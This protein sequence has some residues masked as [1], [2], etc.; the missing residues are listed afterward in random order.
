MAVQ[1]KPISPQDLLSKIIR[2]ILRGFDQHFGI[3]H[4]PDAE[5]V[6]VTICGQET[7]FQ[8]TRQVLSDGSP[9]PATGRWQFEKGG[10]VR[11]V[12]TH[13]ASKNFAK[14]CVEARGVRWDEAAVWAALENDDYLACAFARLLMWTDPYAVPTEEQA[15]WTMYAD[16]LWRPGKPHPAAWPSNWSIGTEV[17]ESP[18][19]PPGPVS[20]P[21]ADQRAVLVQGLTEIGEAVLRLRDKIKELPT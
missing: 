21:V 4:T 5:R 6:L 1:K 10:G 17:T 7:Q 11:G 13:A 9:G 2:P 16:R 3:P 20:P 8:W 12:M 19:V 15:A 14:I 18:I